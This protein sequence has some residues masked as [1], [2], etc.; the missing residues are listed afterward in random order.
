[1]GT[2]DLLI[3]QMLI[4][5]DHLLIGDITKTF[6]CS[7]EEILCPEKIGSKVWC[8]DLVLGRVHAMENVT[9]ELF[10]LETY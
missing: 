2:P 7:F 1:M 10:E 4:G 8:H 6:V 5:H 3:F 9:Y